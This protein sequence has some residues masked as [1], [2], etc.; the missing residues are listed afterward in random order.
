MGFSVQPTELATLLAKQLYE[1]HNTDGD[2]YFAIGLGD[3]DWDTAPAGTPTPS[4]TDNRLEAEIHRKQPDSVSYLEELQSTATGGST[5]TLVDTART[6]PTDYFNGMVVTVTSGPSSGVSADVQGWNGPTKTFTFE[7]GAFPNGISSGDSY[8]T[9][10]LSLSESYAIRI[11]AQ[12]NNVH[13]ASDGSIREELIVVDASDY[14]FEEAGTF[15]GTVIAGS[16]EVVVDSV[17]YSNA[18]VGDI[19]EMDDGGGTTEFRRLLSKTFTAPDYVLTLSGDLTYSY[20]S[21]VSNVI[22]RYSVT[23]GTVVRLIRDTKHVKDGTN[24]MLKTVVLDFRGE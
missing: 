5:N 8:E 24:G 7:A 11:K 20:N 9:Y 18:N 10:K 13:T 4:A 12:W 2:M 23:E 1:A 21:A 17:F 6:E 15:S 22:N 19:I 14:V 3:S 16:S